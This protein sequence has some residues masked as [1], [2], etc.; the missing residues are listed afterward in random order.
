MEQKERQENIIN[1]IK[2]DIDALMNADIE[3]MLSVVELQDRKEM[4]EIVHQHISGGTI[5]EAKIELEN[6]TYKGF[7]LEFNDQVYYYAANKRFGDRLFKL[8]NGKYSS[9]TIDKVQNGAGIYLD[10]V[11]TV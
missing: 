8:V 4:Y 7:K 10:K 3:T 11:V 9:V 1:R 2:N 5:T 6:R